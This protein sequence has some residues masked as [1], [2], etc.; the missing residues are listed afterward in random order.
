VLAALREDKPNL[1]MEGCPKDGKKEMDIDF[2]KKTT[3]GDLWTLAF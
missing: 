1:P 3:Q 2:L